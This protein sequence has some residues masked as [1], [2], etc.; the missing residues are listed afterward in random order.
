[1]EQV[2]NLK[3]PDVAFTDEVM[4][5]DARPFVGF[6]GDGE[7]WA[8]QRAGTL[9]VPSMLNLIARS[10]GHYTD[11]MVDIRSGFFAN[12]HEALWEV[13]VSVDNEVVGRNQFWKWYGHHPVIIPLA[14]FFRE[15]TYVT[16]AARPAGG[17]VQPNRVPIFVVEPIICSKKNVWD[18]LEDRSI[19]VFST[20][21]SGSTWIAHDILGWRHRARTVD[22]SGVGRMFAPLSWDAERFF[23]VERRAQPYESGLAYETGELK[24]VVPGVPPFERSF[25]DLGREL[26]ILNHMNFDLFHRL[27]RDAALEHVLNEWG[28]RHYTQ[29]VFKMPN[30]SHAAD[31]IM[32]AFPRSRM[33]FL[34]RDGRD[35]MRS[36]FTPFASLDLAATKDLELRRYAIAFYAHFWNFEIDIINAAYE[37]HDPSLRYFLRYEDIRTNPE[38][39]INNLLEGIGMPLPAEE[40]AQLVEEA[41]LEN[42]PPETRGP[43]KARQTGRVG[44]Y[45]GSFSAE[46]IELMNSIMRDNL[47]RYGYEVD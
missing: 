5:D 9:Q 3:R 6:A 16:I 31:F 24:R 37:A 19:W 43:D 1:M 4:T 47:L 39:E 26:Q 14:K 10:E 18:T 28:V 23:A 32:R 8:F 33:I 13:T 34:M 45:R 36:R 42:M 46:E 30:D 20:A 38:T 40:L 25:R 15:T 44:G 7:G 21:R 12:Y 17:E 22:E 27:L 41:K 29:L 35:V 11:L 2:F